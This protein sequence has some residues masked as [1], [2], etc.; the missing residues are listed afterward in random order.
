[1]RMRKKYARGAIRNSRIGRSAAHVVEQVEQRVLL[2]SI[3][4]DSAADSIAV[5]GHVTL[6]EAIESANVNAPIDDD[7][8]E[9]GRASCRERV[10]LVV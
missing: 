5:D 8:V 6:R 9:I 7:V 10:C 3:V 2:A 1:M 4:V